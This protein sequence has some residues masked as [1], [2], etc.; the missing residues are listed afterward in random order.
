MH[1]CCSELTKCSYCWQ[2]RR[3]ESSRR[4]QQHIKEAASHARLWHRAS[5]SHAH[6]T[7]GCYMNLTAKRRAM[8]A[9][10]NSICC[11]RQDS[12]SQLHCMFTCARRS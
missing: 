1:A 2:R 6:S 10:S 4:R 5:G 12:H 11:T 3:E 7:M 8:L 9:T